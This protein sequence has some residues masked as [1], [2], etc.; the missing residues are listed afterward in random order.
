M[1]IE[2]WRESRFGMFIHW[3][4]YSGLEGIWQGKETPSLGEWIQAHMKIPV[5]VYREQAKHLTLAKFDAEFW[6]NMAKNAGMKYIVLTSKHHDG[7]AMYDSPASDYNIV[8][9]GPSGRD[10]LRELA[11]A[12][13]K[14]GLKL[15]LYYSQSLDFEDPNGKW[16]DWDYD[17][18]KK[19]FD[20]FFYGKCQAQLREILT[21]YGEIALVWFDVPMDITEKYGRQLRD[22]VKTLQPD[23]LISGRI[24]E[25]PGFEDFGSFGDNSI[26]VGK[27]NGDWETAGTLN[28]TWGYKRNDH[29]WKTPEQVI[30]NL[31]QLASKGANYLLNIGPK[32]DGS[33]PPETID[34]FAKVG[35]WVRVNGEAVY[36][37]AATPFIA[38]F[39]WGWCTQKGNSLYFAVTGELDSAAFSGLINQVKSGCV[40]G[41]PAVKVQISQ[42][43]IDLTL[44][45][46]EK[47][48]KLEVFKLELDGAPQ[49]V[50]L[51]CQQINGEVIIPAY[52]AK[53][54][55]VKTDTAVTDATDLDAAKNAEA[56][57]LAAK[58]VMNVDFAGLIANWDSTKNSAEWD[59]EIRFPGKYMVKVTT[60][61]QK[62]KDWV[63][64]HELKCTIGKSSCQGVLKSDCRPETANSQFFQETISH[65]V[66]IDIA[67]AGKQHLLLEAVAINPADPVGV[68]VKELILSKVGL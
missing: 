57:N 61:A 18:S 40:L 3:G 26:P 20:K 6:V 54:N 68:M 49:V 51:P 39:S 12:A 35:D 15:G 30:N 58:K 60:F 5:P 19:D 29:H 37:T 43:G 7:F 1:S 25:Y 13:R 36:G 32:A 34:I 66:V 63:G 50:T 52:L 53:L 2:W 24:S 62:Y 67:A 21:N 27:L 33:I 42:N 47:L 10:P 56:N 46:S 8:K 22:W 14:A 48:H 31:I 28:H 17:T 44:R 23:C 11:D 64:G 16:N 59:F 38:D 9:Q 41:R 55:I 65:L 4:I 45:F